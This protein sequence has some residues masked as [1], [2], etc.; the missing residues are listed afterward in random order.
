[1]NS[2]VFALAKKTWLIL[3]LVFTVAYIGHFFF[4]QAE[5]VHRPLTFSLLFAIITV[6][7]QIAYWLIV[8]RLWA[9]LVALSSNARIPIFHSFCQLVLVNIG[10]Y[11]PGKVWGI[12]ARGAHM[13]RNGVTTGEALIATFHEQYFLLQSSVVLSGILGAIVFKSAWAWGL[14]LAAA[15]TLLLGAPLQRWALGVFFHLT[16]KARETTTAI[17]VPTLDT[18]TY[19]SMTGKFMASWIVNG[20]VFSGIYF[21]FFQAGITSDLVFALILA[22]TVGV[23]IGFLALFAPGGIGVREAIT[24]GILGQF[25]PLADAIFL[26]LLFRLWLVA[27]DFLLGS[28]VIVLTRKHWF[29]TGSAT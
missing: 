17:S 25:I 8:S 15:A 13:K 4:Q 9:R 6:I 22:N 20:L 7:I 23:T 29:G 14:A 21:T 28:A 10:K 5:E 16:R 27:T 26:S 2:R 1:M 19:L 3:F 11:I 18:P 12:V 24:S